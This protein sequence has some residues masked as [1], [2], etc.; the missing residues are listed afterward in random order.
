MRRSLMTAQSEEPSESM[1]V[2]ALAR[3]ELKS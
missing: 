3:D 1:P 2:G